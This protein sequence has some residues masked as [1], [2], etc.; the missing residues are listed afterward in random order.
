M[1]FIAANF[2]PASSHRRI[3]TGGEALPGAPAIHTYRTQDA[4]ATVDNSGYFNAVAAH[5]N[6]GDLLYC[7]V[8]NSSGV[9]QTAGL[10]IVMTKSAAGVVD[11]GTVTVLVVTNS[12]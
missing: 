5:M 9:V 8:V 10:H 3:G 12:D 11:V 6:V 4:H 2:A 7:V 1:P